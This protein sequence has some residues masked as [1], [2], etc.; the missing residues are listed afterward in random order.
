MGKENLNFAT[1]KIGPLFRA[2]FFPTLVG[3]LFTSLITVVDGIFVGRGVGANGIAAVN[4]VAPT[5]MVATGIGLMFGIGASVVASIRLASDNLKG[6]RIVMTQG[7]VAAC[8]LAL[9]MLIPMTAAPDGVLSLLGCS[10]ELHANAVHYM[11]PLVPGIFFVMIQCIGMMLVRLDGSPRY[12]MWCQAVPAIVNIVLDYIM[13]FPMGMGVKGASVAT[14]ISCVLGGVM[15]LVYFLWF[16]NKLK[17]YRLSRSA[18][19]I[20]RMLRNIVYMVKIGLA[21]FVTE[22]AMSVMMVTGNYMFMNRLGEQG[23]AAYSIACYLFPV[24][25]SIANA[26]AQ[27]A[28]PIISFNYGA[29]KGRRVAAALKLALVTALACGV[30]VSAGLW[31]GAPWMV[32]MFLNPGQEA[33]DLAVKGLPIFATCSI[34]FAVNVTFIGYYQSIEHAATSITYTLLRGVVL[35]IPSFILMPDLLGNTGLWLAI[36]AAEAL[37]TLIILFFFITG[38]NRPQ[39]MKI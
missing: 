38:R 23:V 39:I 19:S 11:L 26:V 22:V 33:F 20:A 30:A 2:M 29:R 7:F 14:S 34:F 31:A 18:K 3:M 17:F 24:V 6:A 35:M 28:Q 32:S 15:V 8:A 10:P 21:T 25:F 16:S 37:T 12:A 4:I 27:S 1:M 36:P 5:F 13:I 9:V